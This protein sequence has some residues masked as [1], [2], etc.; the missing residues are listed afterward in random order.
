MSDWISVKDR[1][2]EDFKEVLACNGYGDMVVGKRD[3]EMSAWIFND[4]EQLVFDDRV[5]GTK[6]EIKAWMPLPETYKE[7]L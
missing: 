7:E 3:S 6:G 2:P 4:Y 1:I 5:K